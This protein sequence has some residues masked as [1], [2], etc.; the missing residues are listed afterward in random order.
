MYCPDELPGTNK[1]TINRGSFG[2]L[3]GNAPDIFF[4]GDADI[5]D[6]GTGIRTM[7]NGQW[8]MDNCWY[9]PDGRK[10][11]GKPTHPGVYLYNGNK[12]IIK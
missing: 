11:S 5:P 6:D 2:G 3:G 12:I 9:A 10:L 8:I 7:D 1:F 4:T